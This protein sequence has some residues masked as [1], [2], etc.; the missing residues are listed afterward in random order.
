MLLF[1]TLQAGRA[2][3]IHAMAMQRHHRKHGER[4]QPLTTRSLGGVPQ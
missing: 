3:F 2:C 4:H 1:E